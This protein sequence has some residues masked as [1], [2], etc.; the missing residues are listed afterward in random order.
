[1]L[2]SVELHD[3]KKLNGKNDD[4]CMPSATTVLLVSGI[5]GTVVS[6]WS[7]KKVSV[8]RDLKCNAPSTP[9]AECFASADPNVFLGEV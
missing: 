2:R 1:M 5:Q 7:L 8:S 9:G 3:K 6:Y 4:R